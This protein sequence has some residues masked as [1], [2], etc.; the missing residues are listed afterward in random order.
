MER[1]MAKG[2]TVGDRLRLAREARG[3]SQAALGEACDVSRAAVS[4]WEAND[5]LPTSENLELAAAKLNCSMDWLKTAK[6]KAPDLRAAP[7]VGRRHPRE[8]GII[9]EPSPNPGAIPEHAMGIGAGPM[10]L[11]GRVH[12]WWQLPQGLVTETLRTGVQS[13]VML[14]VL[15]DSM[16]PA[17]KRNDYVLV[18]RFQV[19]PGDDQIFAIDNGVGAVL[20]RVRIGT[21]GAITLRSDRDP[22]QDITLNRKEIRFVGRVIG[23]F[24]IL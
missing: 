7:L 9:L 16:S 21:D 4:Q 22:D 15:S 12:D 14:R 1:A 24:V 11:D 20:R 23:A 13:L 17:L 6:G 5:H 18:D 8:G 3:F 2:G 19:E 10:V